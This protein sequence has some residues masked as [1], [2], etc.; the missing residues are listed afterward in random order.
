MK[1]KL[2]TGLLAT[3]ACCTLM[4]GCSLGD[5]LKP[6]NPDDSAEAPASTPLDEAKDYVKE[7]YKGA[8]KSTS[9]KY[10]LINQVPVGDT[11][12]PITW[13]SPEE[14]K[15][16][17]IVKG[18]KETTV[19]VIHEILN[20]KDLTY[21]LKATITAPDGKTAEVEFKNLKAVYSNL[22]V[23]NV[24]YKLYLEQKSEGKYYFLNG[25][26]DGSYFATVDDATNAKEFFVEAVDG[27]SFK[28]YYKV[29]EAKKYISYDIGQNNKGYTKLTTKYADTTDYTFSYDGTG[30]YWYTTV[31]DESFVLGTHGSYT[32]M[33]FSDSY[34]YSDDSSS[35]DS[36]YPMQMVKASDVSSLP[37][38]IPPEKPN[39]E[40][41][42]ANS[43]ITI[44]KAIEIGNAHDSDK[45]TEDKYYIVAKI[46]EVYNAEYG[47]MIL[48]DEAGNEL[49]VYGTYDANGTNGYKDM[50]NKP[51]V[52]NTIKV[53][54]KIGK[55]NTTPQMKDGWITEVTPGSGSGT[56]ETPS[57][58]KVPQAITAAPTVDTAYKLHLTQTN[59]SKELYF[60]GTMNENFGVAT[61][62]QAEAVDVYVE[63]TTNG[64][65]LYMDLD[66]KTYINVVPSYNDSKA[67]WYNNLNLAATAS[68]VWVW[69]DTNKI[70]TTN[71][72]NDTETVTVYIGT[73][74]NYNSFSVSAI[75]YLNG[76]FAAH[77]SILVDAPTTDDNP[78]P[79]SDEITIKDAIALGAGADVKVTG[80]IID[81]ADATN[82]NMTIADEHGDYIY[83]YKATIP[84]S[85]TETISVGKKITLDGSLSVYNGVIQV[86]K[87]TATA[88]VAAESDTLA[89]IYKVAQIA[90]N[91][92]VSTSISVSGEKSLPVTDSAFEGSTISWVSD[93]D[94]AVVNNDKVTY[95]LQ[96][97]ATTVTLKATVTM[98]T[99]NHT[100]D[101][102]INLDKKPADNE[103]PIKFTDLVAQEGEGTQYAN[104][105]YTLSADV[106]MTI[107]KCHLHK[108]GEVRIYSSSANDGIVIF[109]STKVIDKITL[110]VG[111]KADTLNVYG[112]TDGTTWTLIQGIT[113]TAA[114]ADATVEIENSTYKHIKLDVA[115]TNQVRMKS[116]T[117]TFAS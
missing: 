56:P 28:I 45:Y 78:P 79:S 76:S 32:T 38:P 81:I 23:E 89:D 16:I 22:P 12:Y 73:Y 109:T 58:T 77:L 93:K 111:N 15:G 69:D 113:T 86:N 7:L 24:A 110:N 64:F 9:T 115:G 94:F 112:S 102:I 74:N 5:L 31:E 63:A 18:E 50:A 70:L 34:Y 98:G 35:K 36:Q 87:P 61:E 43:V 62:N 107:D 27:T 41:P 105:T 54:G 91:M 20:G 33:S 68:S 85:I 95:T 55:F 14:G 10:T 117:F 65:Y 106:S 96:T 42:A 103:L 26:M 40:L 116:I 51:V 67:K 90:M 52:G 4:T 13:S 114:Y 47:N 2:I 25:E 17:E 80:T 97:E 11:A 99:A 21:T 29:G 1:K 3:L 84:E 66:T 100:Y 8:N 59:T 53:Y 39:I 46:K 71:V 83:V 88:L 101:F 6:I 48:V 57:E 37:T 44:A 75:S 104:E 60:A 19:Q 72:I 30:N 82:N 92:N 49:T 108:D